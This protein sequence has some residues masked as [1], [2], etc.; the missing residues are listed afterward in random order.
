MTKEEI[1]NLIE[2]T[3]NRLSLEAEIDGTLSQLDGLSNELKVSLPEDAPKSIKDYV[4]AAKK[5]YDSKKSYLNEL[6]KQLKEVNH[7]IELL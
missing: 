5:S 6:K 7:E 1:I 3:I 2:L 4:E